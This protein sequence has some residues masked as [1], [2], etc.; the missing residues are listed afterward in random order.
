MFLERET[1]SAC[2]QTR[3]D[4]ARLS[5]FHIHTCT[6]HPSQINSDLL[7]SLKNTECNTQI[8]QVKRLQGGSHTEADPNVCP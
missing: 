1:L 2:W 8:W 7:L 6:H 3:G 4:Q 5:S